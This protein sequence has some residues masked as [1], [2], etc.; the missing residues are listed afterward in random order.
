M[1]AELTEAE[2]GW[3]SAHP[4]VRWGADPDWPPFSSLDSHGELIGIDADITRLAAE[5]VG[6]RVTV[7]PAASW[8]EVL[9]KAKAREVDFLSGTSKTSGRLENF[10]Y[11]AD[12]GAFPVVIITRN[13]APFLTLVPDL[14]SL[15]IASARDH[16]TTLQ[17]QRDFPTAHFVLTR[18]AEEALE[19]VARGTVDATVQN[20]AVAT[21]AIRLNGLT[22]LKISGITKYE[23]PLRFAVRKDAPEL[24]SLLNKGLDTIT[25]QEQ[26]TIFAAHLTPDVAKAR[27]WGMWRRW[28]LSSALIGAAAV[29]VV[30]LWNFSL[31]R[32]IRRRNAAEAALLET[33]DRLERRTVELDLRV[34]EVEKLNSELHLANEDLQSFSSSVSHDLRAPLRRI[35]SFAELL[36]RDAAQHLTGRPGQYI[37]FICKESDRMERL[38]QDLLEFA[39]VGRAKLHKETVNMDQLVKDVID[40]CLPQ[41][42][43]RRVVWKIGELGARFWRSR[44]VAL[45]PNQ[46]NR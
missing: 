33:R 35:T 37:S 18:T 43:D 5:R 8:S 15:S 7:V 26:E 11:T 10:D 34:A 20:L 38:I 21:R 23:F 9:A 14:R 17:L 6:L 2:R 4:R 28:A 24:T 22:N 29:L 1:T 42:R 46:P 39:R 16:V 31:S 40:D 27:D 45:C 25:D 41:V 36:Q 3:L 44:P 32:Q 19:L 30:V 12:Y 13:E